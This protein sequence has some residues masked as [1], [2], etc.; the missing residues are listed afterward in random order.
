MGLGGKGQRQKFFVCF[1]FVCFTSCFNLW[2]TYRTS[3]NPLSCGRHS[4][5]FRLKR[6]VPII[7]ME[8]FIHMEWPGSNTWLITAKRQKK[9]NKSN[10]QW[11]WKRGW[12]QLKD[13]RKALW[14]VGL[15]RRKQHPFCLKE[16]PQSSVNLRF[17]WG[18]PGLQAGIPCLTSPGDS[19]TGV[20]LPHFGKRWW[21]PEVS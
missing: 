1:L 18:V 9:D 5:G 10:V 17:T 16:E 4:G 3:T 12:S 6:K 13:S 21:Q 14:G 15:E 7:T 8:R 20:S 2:S 11:H 19:V